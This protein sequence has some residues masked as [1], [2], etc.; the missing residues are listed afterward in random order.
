MDK[1]LLSFLF[2]MLN[3][4][5]SQFLSSHGRCFSPLVI[6]TL[7]D[8]L[9]L[10]VFL[11]SI[12]INA[13]TQ[14][15]KEQSAKQYFNNVRISPDMAQISLYYFCSKITNFQAHVN[16]CM[17][18]FQQMLLSQHK[19]IQIC[20]QIILHVKCQLP[21]DTQKA[22]TEIKCDHCGTLEYS[23]GQAFFP[24]VHS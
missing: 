2:S 4:V 22:S 7:Q 9:F 15:R 20:E 11:H 23:C 17:T 3:S 1:I 21:I 13:Q 18:Y 12:T 16:F 19:K 8:G 10:V 5:S 6:N 14:I 24:L